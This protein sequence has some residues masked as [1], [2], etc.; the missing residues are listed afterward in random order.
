MKG[1]S[2]KKEELFGIFRR[3]GFSSRTDFIEHMMEELRIRKDNNQSLITL[4]FIFLV[5]VIFNYRKFFKSLKKNFYQFKIVVFLRILSILLILLS[6]YSESAFSA[7]V[8]IS[9]NITPFLFV[10]KE[11]HSPA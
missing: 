3:G 5:K 4:F 7:S 2:T 10:Q 8:D 11:C 1:V 9:S 6:K